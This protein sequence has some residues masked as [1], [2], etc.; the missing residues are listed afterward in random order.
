MTPVRQVY[1]P[2]NPICPGDEWQRGNR[3]EWDVVPAFG[4]GSIDG[5]CCQHGQTSQG[6]RVPGERVIS[7]PLPDFHEEH[8]KGNGRERLPEFSDLVID[9]RSN[10]G[11]AG[12]GKESAE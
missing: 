1:A 6:V 8:G 10:E 11:R 3:V 2:G 5:Q 9:K 4:A 12:K 7:N